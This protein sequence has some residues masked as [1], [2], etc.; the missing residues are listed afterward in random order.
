MIWCYN[1]TCPSGNTH[2]ISFSLFFIQWDCTFASQMENEQANREKGRELQPL[3]RLIPYVLRYPLTLFLFV[4]FLGLAAA[5]TLALPGAFRLVVDCGFGG[6]SESA[7][8]TD[9]LPNAEL[10]T[11]FLLSGF[12]LALKDGERPIRGNPLNYQPIRGLYLTLT[13]T[14]E[15]GVHSHTK[16]FMSRLTK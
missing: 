4:I 16:F 2:I 5:L 15:Q 7:L 6:A 9:L 13:N 12:C 14:G 10:S 3:S 1:N 8:C 11:F